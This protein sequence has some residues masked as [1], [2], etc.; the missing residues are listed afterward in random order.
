[1]T[2]P[3]HILFIMN[4]QRGDRVPD[5]FS[6]DNTPHHAFF[7]EVLFYGA[8]CR[9]RIHRRCMC[10]DGWLNPRNKRIRVSCSVRLPECRLPFSSGVSHD[11]N[12]YGPFDRRTP[13]YYNR[14]QRFPEIRVTLT[15]SLRFRKSLRSSAVRRLSGLSRITGDQ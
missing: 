14:K 5:I 4:P 8:H 10:M 3:W 1:M 13:D 9:L 6:Q 12:I 11:R 2:N 15:R 7:E